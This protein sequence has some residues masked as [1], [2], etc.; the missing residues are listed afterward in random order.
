MQCSRCGAA[1]N[2]GA[3]ACVACGQP[4]IL[5][6]VGSI[7]PAAVGHVVEAAPASVPPPSAEAS[8]YQ[9]TLG[10]IDR[11]SFFAAQRRNRRATW[12]LAAM[13]AVAAVLTGIPLSLVLTPLLFAVVL[14]VTRL[15]GLVV[16]VP[17]GVWSAYQWVGLAL[18]RI[19]DAA[20]D[21]TVRQLPI[22]SLVLAASIWLLPGIAAM[23]AM[24][25]ALRALFA[26]A[27]VG[28]MLL[29]LGAREPRPDDFEERQLVNVVEEMAIAAGIPAPRVMLIDAP[30]SNA[31][32]LGSSTK[33]AAVIVSRPMLDHLDRDETQGLLA[34][35]VASIA[36]GDLDGARS[37]LAVF[38]TFGF[39]AAVIRM[40]ISGP[41][42]ATVGRMLRYLFGHK[43][44]AER[45][46]EA[47]A[48]SEMLADTAENFDEK[49]DLESLTEEV[50]PPVQRAG[51][52]LE[53]LKAFPFVAL[54]YFI[55]TLVAGWP[56][57]ARNLGFL[58]LFGAAGALILY[59]RVY[60]FWLARRVIA[61]THAI[62]ILPYYLAAMMP[63]ILLLFL[64]MLVLQP[65]FGLLW[66]TRRYLADA[67]AVQLTRNPE[68][69]ARG[70]AAQAEHGCGVAGSGWA[71]PMFVSGAA[72][73][74][75]VSPE[76]VAMRQQLMQE[77]AAEMANP[78]APGM[79]EA[80]HRAQAVADIRRRAME[81]M[82]EAAIENPPASKSSG[83]GGIVSMHPSVNRRLRR[84][85]RMGAAVDDVDP[86]VKRGH[87]SR[88]GPASFV[89]MPVVFVLV[90][91]LAVLM[92]ALLAVLI[93]VSVLFASVLMMMV[94]GLFAV[95]IPR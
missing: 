8:V 15:L 67:T 81:Q 80:E 4:L 3:L 70:L 31:A 11:E 78:P 38:Q 64:N 47:R 22:G 33:D 5:S 92:L 52:K 71:L 17:D 83:F 95:L 21:S 24:W 74:G 76:A 77:L 40:P 19:F 36:N 59:Q 90:A 14:V 62:I 82:P 34:H 27:G 65:A 88:K 49:N 53:L 44:E 42:R 50:T 55:Y 41:A 35:L 54:G 79:S 43:R 46:D 18:K 69:L 91:V 60:A 23:L 61:M 72:N 26:R 9:P 20:S 57:A 66:R 10:P 93:A 1:N 73:M 87:Q 2:T 29:S 32:M 39:A 48:L 6:H 45:L 16:A 13:S 37:M 56:D 63:Q 86:R 94:Y 68:G 58:I 30:I 12:R 84:L 7:M 51:P 75:S 85:R 28:G 89:V 25:V